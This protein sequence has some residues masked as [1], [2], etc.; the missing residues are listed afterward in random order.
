[1]NLL[2]ELTLL[3]VDV[4]LDGGAVTE[5]LP[6]VRT[7][8]LLS[9]LAEKQKRIFT[10]IRLIPYTTCLNINRSIVHQN[11]IYLL[12]VCVFLLTR[13]FRKSIEAAVFVIDPNK[14]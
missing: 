8:D 14:H 9:S 7:G 6:D 12:F 1:M 3:A 11:E 4:F 5:S 2:A 10:L 13:K